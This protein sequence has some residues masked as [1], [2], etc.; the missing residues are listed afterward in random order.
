M[1]SDLQLTNLQKQGHGHKAPNQSDLSLSRQPEL[2]AQICINTTST[3]AQIET[4]KGLDNSTCKK[5]GA[6]L[7]WPQST[8]RQV[9]FS[10]PST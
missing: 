5:I 6:R 2:A 9:P 1:Q 8:P 3:V 10:Q 7:A 4:W